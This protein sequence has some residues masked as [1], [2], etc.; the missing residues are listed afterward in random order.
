LCYIA[1]LTTFEK[2]LS[3]A[4]I[5]L[6]QPSE[7]SVSGAPMHGKPDRHHALRLGGLIPAYACLFRLKLIA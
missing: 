1:F 6:F 2:S 4:G 5:S 7:K 3:Q